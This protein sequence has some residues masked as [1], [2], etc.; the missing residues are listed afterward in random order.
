MMI[1]TGPFGAFSAVHLNP[2]AAVAVLPENKRPGLTVSLGAELLSAIMTVI[3]IAGDRVEFGC[4]IDRQPDA[5]GRRGITRQ[6]SCVHCDA[7]P[8]E[9][10]H[11][12]HL[13]TLINA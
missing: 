5:T 4:K 9:P 10:L 12:R 6:V 3:P 13:R 1:D 8:G 2:P 7:G 11:V